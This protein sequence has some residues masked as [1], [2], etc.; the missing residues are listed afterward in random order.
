M[1]RTVPTS[2][3]VWS[4]EC[5][6]FFPNLICTSSLSLEQA[7]CVSDTERVSVLMLLPQKLT[8]AAYYLV[9]TSYWGQRDFSALLLQSH[10]VLGKHN[11]LHLLGGNFQLSFISLCL[12]RMGNGGWGW[13]SLGKSEIPAPPQQ[14]CFVS[15]QKFRSLALSIFASATAVEWVCFLWEKSLYSTPILQQ[16]L[17]QVF[18]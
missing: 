12:V 2:C 6:S 14:L 15:L 3:L 11:A 16:L 13:V 9:Q 7:L 5:R 4:P 1:L 18:S 8:V 10:S 17:L